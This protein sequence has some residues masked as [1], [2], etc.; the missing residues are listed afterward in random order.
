[1]PTKKALR[2]LSLNQWLFLIAV[3]GWTFLIGWVWADRQWVKDGPNF[4]D[5]CG[6]TVVVQPNKYI[7][8]TILRLQ[9]AVL[10]PQQIKIIQ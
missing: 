5:Q 10:G 2:L 4:P 1:M 8:A 9:L 3:C 7:A 6:H